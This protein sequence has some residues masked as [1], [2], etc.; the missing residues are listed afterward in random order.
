MKTNDLLDAPA[1]GKESQYPSAKRTYGHHSRFGCRGKDKKNLCSCLESNADP[2]VF[3][4]VAWSLR[5]LNCNDSV[6]L[7]R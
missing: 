3:Q 1:P 4:T 6:L 5:R 7:S 2:S